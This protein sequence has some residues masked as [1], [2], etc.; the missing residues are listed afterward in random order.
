VSTELLVE[1]DEGELGAWWSSK[2]LW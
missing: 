2:N 1:L